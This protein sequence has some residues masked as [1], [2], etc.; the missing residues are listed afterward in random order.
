MNY[1]FS[2]TYELETRLISDR[3]S[4][5]LYRRQNCNWMAKVRMEV[6]SWTKLG[7]IKWIFITLFHAPSIDKE[8]I[9]GGA[10]P[11]RLERVNRATKLTRECHVEVITLFHIK[12]GHVRGEGGRQGWSG[13]AQ[14]PQW[15]EHQQIKHHQVQRPY[16][17]HYCVLPARAGT[18]ENMLISTQHCFYFYSMAV[19]LKPSKSL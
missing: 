4:Y 18:R 8:A 9:R 11:Q 19:K 2:C 1:F 15:A 17:T 14:H 12:H 7:L 3:L 6:W 10:N 13:L 5:I 16:W